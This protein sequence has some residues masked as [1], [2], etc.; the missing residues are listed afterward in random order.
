[1][2]H[3]NVNMSKSIIL[4][5]KSHLWS[6][7]DAAKGGNTFAYEVFPPND[8][9][10]DLNQVGLWCFSGDLNKPDFEEFLGVCPLFDFLLEQENFDF[11]KFEVSWLFTFYRINKKL[12]ASMAEN[13]VVRKNIREIIAAT[14]KITKIDAKDKH[15]LQEILVDYFC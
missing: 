6:K 11:R 5:V 13:D 14:L 3:C 9:Y 12:L 10:E 7:I 8:P 1:M 15:R 2:V 4:Q